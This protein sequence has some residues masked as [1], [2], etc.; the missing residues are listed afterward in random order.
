MLRKDRTVIEPKCEFG[1]ECRYLQ[2]EVDGTG[3]TSCRY[4][5][6]KEHYDK[7]RNGRTTQSQIQSFDPLRAQSKVKSFTAE[8]PVSNARGLFVP[9][10][11][12]KLLVAPSVTAVLLAD[13]SLVV[14][15]CETATSV[16]SGPRFADS[17]LA[18]IPAKTL[19]CGRR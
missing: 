17:A 18:N 6:P 8:K 4:F 10:S 2:G 1:I 7:L 9:A 11:A 14:V 15:E 16:R 5:H 19:C 13:S 12:P 3:S